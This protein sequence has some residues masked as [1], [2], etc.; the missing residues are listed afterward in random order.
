MHS[1]NLP[2]KYSNPKGKCP[3]LETV[4]HK[5]CSPVELSSCGVLCHTAALCSAWKC[6]FA[7]GWSSSRLQA[8]GHSKR[9]HLAVLFAVSWLCGL[10]F[11]TE[12]ELSY[13]NAHK[14]DVVTLSQGTCCTGGSTLRD[15]CLNAFS[16]IK[17]RL[18][19][20]YNIQ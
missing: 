11:Q 17:I 6:L 12:H 5:Q 4:V 16:D 7:A 3:G 9:A 2:I 10:H 19:F 18:M 15:Y 13:R 14:D 20:K 1:T 8:P